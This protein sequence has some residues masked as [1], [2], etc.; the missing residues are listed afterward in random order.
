MINFDDVTGENRKN[1]SKLAWNSWSHVLN[2]EKH[3]KTNTL[4]NFSNYSLPIVF[5]RV[6]AL[7]QVKADNI[8]ENLLIEIHHIIFTVSSKRN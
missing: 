3:A 4:L 2:Q 7:A 6:R 5:L 1:T 8:S